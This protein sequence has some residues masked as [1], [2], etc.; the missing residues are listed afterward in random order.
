M[1][2]VDRSP[3]EADKIAYGTIYQH[4]KTSFTKHSAAHGVYLLGSGAWQVKDIPRGGKRFKSAGDTSG[5]RAG[6]ASAEKIANQKSNQWSEQ[7]VGRIAMTPVGVY[8][9]LAFSKFF[10]DC[11]SV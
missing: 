2:A 11:P 9:L 5:R 4:L 8:R 6:L 1:E 7:T 10:P 3:D